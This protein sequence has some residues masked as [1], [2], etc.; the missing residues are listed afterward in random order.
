MPS[1]MPLPRPAQQAATA[2]LPETGP[3]RPPLETL[4]S[5]ATLAASRR[6]PGR[7]WS[8]GRLPQPA[9]HA[10]KI[11]SRRAHSWIHRGIEEGGRA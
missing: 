8:A 1:S 9:L 2:S 6:A 5:I 10:G 3:E 11:A 4:S 7:I